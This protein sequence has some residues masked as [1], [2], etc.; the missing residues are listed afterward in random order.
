VRNL[1]ITFVLPMIDMAGGVRS[2]FEL[3]N[4]LQER[5]HNVSIVYPLISLRNGAEWYDLRSLTVRVFRTMRN[6]IRGNRV[7]WFDL[8]ANLIRVPTLAEKYIPKGDI[9]IATWWANAY[10]VNK[11]ENDKGKKFYFIRHYEIWGGPEDLVDGTYKLPLHKIVTSNWLKELIEKKFNVAVF[12]PVSN[13]INFNLFY[14]ELNTFDCHKPRRIGMVYRR[15]TWK[16]MKDGFQ[17][18]MKA[19]Q[20]YKDV[21]LV[22]FG[23]RLKYGDAKI[24][25]RIGNVEF[26]GSLSKD[27]LR[28]A[29]NSLDI[30]MFPS[31]IEG[32]GNPPME[33]MACG[34]ACI[35]TNV[36]GIPDYIIDG[37][38][39]LL[40]A[41][42]LPDKLSDHLLYLLQNEEK[43]KEIARAGYE[44]IQ[45]FAWDR[46]VDLLEDI[47][48]KVL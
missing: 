3:A 27:K 5:G 34:T 1:K 4:R 26:Y 2:T 40:C 12:G 29:Y 48:N 20:K 11:Y 46:S 17:T 30:F 28:K 21:Q 31:H 33:A 18:F 8:K 45:Q 43:R 37:K 19:K 22:L 32:F 35:S 24:I 47:F 39:G 25:K 7:D 36:G 14:R 38:T 23:Q 10:D 42:N 16:G 41:P 15:E 44:H 6:I 9:I 13:G